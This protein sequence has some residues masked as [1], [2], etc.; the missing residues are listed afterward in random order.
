[1]SEQITQHIN[2]L[3][4]QARRE[5]DRAINRDLSRHQSEGMLKRNITVVLRQAY[6][7]S[8]DGN[9]TVVFAISV[10]VAPASV[11]YCHPFIVPVYPDKIK[12]SG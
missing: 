4:V 6:E 11:E 7:Q 10:Q 8:I 3:R 5:Y 1:M 12:P 9:E 2:R